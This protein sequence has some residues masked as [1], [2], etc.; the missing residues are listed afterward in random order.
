MSSAGK[1]TE[2]VFNSR[3]CDSLHLV[4]IPGFAPFPTSLAAEHAMILCEARRVCRGTGRSSKCPC[5]PVARTSAMELG[6]IQRCHVQQRFWLWL[7]RMR[8]ALRWMFPALE[9]TSA[10]SS[11]LLLWLLHESF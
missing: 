8:R 1:L 2:T 5:E 6:L 10:L 9:A 7:C 11:D 3:N 4:T